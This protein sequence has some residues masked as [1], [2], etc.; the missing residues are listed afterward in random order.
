[1]NAALCHCPKIVPERCDVAWTPLCLWHVIKAVVTHARQTFRRVV[2]EA[3]SRKQNKQVLVDSPQHRE[4]CDAFLAIVWSTTESEYERR[5]S[6][7]HLLSA[8]E[9]K[10]VD[11][12][13]LTKWKTRIVRFWTN[14]ILHFGLQTTSRVEGYH[15]S[16][17][18]WLHSSTGDLLH[19]HV[20][21]EA[22]WLWSLK[23]HKD[24]M[25]DTQ[26]HARLDLAVP[27]FRRVLKRVH[28]HALTQC[29]EQ[30]QLLTRSTCTGVYA[31][32]RGLPC[33]H[34]LRELE[35]ESKP[36][37]LSDFHPHWWVDRSQATTTPP[38]QAQDP[39]TS[40]QMRVE[41]ALARRKSTPHVRGR[42]PNG[43]RRLPSGFELSESSA[44]PSLSTRLDATTQGMRILPPI[45]FNP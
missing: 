18:R 25:S 22:W 37:L 28:N 24:A 33:V 5:R 20:R 41:A 11:D 21:L 26:V 44:L 40:A 43:T 45:R 14:E 9:A 15:R 23:A 1:M 38:P 32:T 4:F 10:Y 34:K 39:S 16:L 2:D 30:L 42:G 35:R 6:V 3:E 36:L 13:W 17:K 7:L 31:K 12:T 29:L 19:L 27:S 8:K